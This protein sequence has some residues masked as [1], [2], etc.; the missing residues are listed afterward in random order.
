M[1]RTVRELAIDLNLS[2]QRVHQAFKVLGLTDGEDY[3]KKAGAHFL[4]AKGEKKL[5]KFFNDAK[6]GRPVKTID[7]KLADKVK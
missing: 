3:I 1:L 6:P 2:T 4:T 5:R 7:K